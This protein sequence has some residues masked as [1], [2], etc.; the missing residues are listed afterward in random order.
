MKE[1]EQQQV[2]SISRIAK[3]RKKF[4]R[5]CAC[6]ATVVDVIVEMKFFT[7]KS[8]MVWSVTI[9]PTASH[10]CAIQFSRTCDEIPIIDIDR[11]ILTPYVKKTIKEYGK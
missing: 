4:K 2:V 10:F 7:K 6:R 11:Q 5:K 8:V 3:Q 9:T 1:I